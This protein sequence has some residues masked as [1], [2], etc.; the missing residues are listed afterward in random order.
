VSVR[1]R[2]SANGLDAEEFCAKKPGLIHA[3]VGLHGDKGPWK[4]RSGFDEIGGAVSEL[5]CIEGTPTH[6]KSPP[7]IPIC[8]N[9]VGWLGTVGIFTACG[10]GRQLSRHCFSD[11]NLAVAVFGR[12]FRQSLCPSDRRIFRRARRR[13]SRSAHGGDAVGQVSRSR[14]PGSFRTVLM[15]E[16]R[17]NPSGSHH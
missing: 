6:P 4:N 10:R 1:L 14:S 3:R 13:R 12:H 5:F 2:T 17:A 8:D 11:P 16:A 9:V 15:P 7:I